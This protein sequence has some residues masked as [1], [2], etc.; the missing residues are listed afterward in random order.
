MEADIMKCGNCG[1]IVPDDLAICN[2]CKKPVIAQT[3]DSDT[4]MCP[5]CGES[6]FKGIK[7]CSKCGSPLTV[8][9]ET[10]AAKASPPKRRRKRRLNPKFV[11]AVVIFFVIVAS[12]AVLLIVSMFNRD[13]AQPAR[14]QSF[15]SKGGD[16]TQFVADGG[17]LLKI[18]GSVVLSA[19]SRDGSSRA[20]LTEGGK[21]YNISSAGSAEVSSNVVFCTISAN[22]SSIPYLVDSAKDASETSESENESTEPGEPETETLYDKSSLSLFLYDCAE[23]TSTLIANNVNNY[24][25]AVSP[26]GKA[27]SYTMASSD[28]KSFEGYICNGGIF[29]SAGKNSCVVAMSDNAEYVYYLKYESGID[30]EIIKFFAKGSES[31]IKLGEFGDASKLSLYLNNTRNEAVF[32]LNGKDGNYFISVSCS[33]KRRVSTGFKPVLSYGNQATRVYGTECS[34]FACPVDS[35]GRTPFTDASDTLYYMDINFAATE[36]CAG[37]ESARVSSKGNMLFYI[38]S[39]EFLYSCPVESLSSKNKLASH[40]SKFEISPDGAKCFYIDGDKSLY[41]LSGDK[42]SLVG[43]DVNELWVTSKGTVYFL[44]NFTF[45]SGTLFCSK[46]GIDKKEVNGADNVSSVIP[47]YSDKVYYC[48]DYSSV[49]GTFDLWYGG[50]DTFTKLFDDLG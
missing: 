39:S 14:L 19:E 46:N 37:V 33:E 26:D 35:F 34:V 2:V 31:E 5:C 40:V 27:V 15:F 10:K 38:D 48:S 8:P 21:L 18:D 12:V 44:E 4:I 25:I 47:D 45:G 6:N 43:S 3:P 16:Y 28:S 41:C 50:E 24:S 29:S 9:P 13:S 30:G 49:S 22:G 32:S 20:V 11:A 17:A 1:S 7:I 23:K 36:V 42:T